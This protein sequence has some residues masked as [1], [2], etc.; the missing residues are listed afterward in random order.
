MTAT[1][2]VPERVPERV[3]P[4]PCQNTRVRFFGSVW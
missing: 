2:R 3:P 1:Q 4:V